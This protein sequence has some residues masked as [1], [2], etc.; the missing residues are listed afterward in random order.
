MHSTSNRIIGSI[1]SFWLF[2]ETSNT[3]QIRIFI[4]TLSIINNNGRI[5]FFRSLNCLHLWWFFFVWKIGCFC[6]SFHLI[7]IHL[8]FN[9]L[10]T[11]RRRCKLSILVSI[12]CL[13]FLGTAFH[14]NLSYLIKS[15]FLTSQTNIWRILIRLVRPCQCIFDAFSTDFKRFP[16]A[17]R[18]LLLLNFTQLTVKQVSFFYITTDIFLIF[19]FS[20]TQ[21]S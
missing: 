21:R 1:T 7:T 9:I 6:I 10:H 20:I 16:A 14:L 17:K 12:T 4:C 5:W 15:F 18:F 2:M 13:P 19:P 8:I 3:L 11:I